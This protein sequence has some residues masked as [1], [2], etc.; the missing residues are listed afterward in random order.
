MWTFVTNIILFVLSNE[1]HKITR[2]YPGSRTDSVVETVIQNKLS[3]Q[4]SY[5]VLM[6][7]VE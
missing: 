3:H 6:K 5:V 1:Q 2:F 4:T 7:A